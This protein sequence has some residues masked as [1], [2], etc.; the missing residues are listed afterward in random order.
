M[1]QT[2]RC[3]F[4]IEA[5]L[6]E[7][8]E[9]QRLSIPENSD[10]QRRLLR[11]LMN[12]RQPAPVADDVLQVQDEYLRRELAAKGIT[13]IDDLQ[14]CAEG[15]YLWQGDITTL[16]VDAIVN[17]A[18]SGMTGCYQP[19]H[20]CIDNAIHTFAGMQLRLAC[21]RI[22]KE[23][24]HLEPTGSAKITSGYNL[25]ARFI[26]HTV[27][28]IVDGVLTARHE[29]ELASCYKSCLALAAEH[30][31]ESVAFCCISTG[32]FG[33]PNQRA[34]EIAVATVRDFLA[35]ETCVKRVVFNVF[36][37]LDLAIYEA[38]LAE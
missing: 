34:A 25:P 32:V 31:L 12:V 20:S 3:H 27:G 11:A 24:G 14:P 4:L 18:N 9:A 16:R 15:L 29:A 21:D 23:Q 22:M 13:D 36:K 6:A 30:H 38:L 28:P 26:L 10:D 2:E 8:D 19:N 37:D 35:Q 1:T 7:Y 5:L 33:F 17:A